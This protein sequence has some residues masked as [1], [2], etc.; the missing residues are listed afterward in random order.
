M[1]NP[2]L[3]EKL[4]THPE[5]LSNQASQQHTITDISWETYEGILADL[6]DDFPSVQVYYLKGLVVEKLG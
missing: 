2:L 1:M 3:L 5:L 6:A 4:N